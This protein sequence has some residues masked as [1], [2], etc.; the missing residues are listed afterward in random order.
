MKL[1]K[2]EKQFNV[3][4][5]KYKETV[6]CRNKNGVFKI[7]CSLLTQGIHT[8]YSLTVNWQ[9]YTSFA[10]HSLYLFIQILVSLSTFN[11]HS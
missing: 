4:Q 2:E 11:V 6:N 3:T 7:V 10:F 8:V 9:S 1:I 5:L